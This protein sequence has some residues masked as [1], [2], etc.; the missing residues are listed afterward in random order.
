MQQEV[1]L[2]IYRSYPTLSYPIYFTLRISAF[3]ETHVDVNVQLV[4][5]SEVEKK[6]QAQVPRTLFSAILCC[7]LWGCKCCVKCDYTFLL[8]NR[9][10][11]CDFR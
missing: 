9:Q 5:S 6:L 3:L 11:F 2:S 1:F 7:G 10:L 8:S 4:G